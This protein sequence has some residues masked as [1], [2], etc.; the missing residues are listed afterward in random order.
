MVAQPRFEP[1]DLPDSASTRP[2]RWRA[3][4]STLGSL[5]A[6]VLCFAAA[7][8]LGNF[9]TEAI[10]M[11]QFFEAMSLDPLGGHGPHPERFLTPLLAWSIGLTGPRYWAFSQLMLIVFLAL[12]HHLAYVRSRSQP[13]ALVFTLGLSVSGIV[14]TYREMPG[15]SEPTTF[16]LV[17]LCLRFAHRGLLFWLLAG[18]CA[19]N[20]GHS[21]LLWPWLAFERSR[22]ARLGWLDGLLAACALAAYVAARGLL[23]RDSVPGQPEGLG[24]SFY[25]G[26]FGWLRTLEFWTFLVPG[27]VFAFGFLLIVLWWDLCGERGRDASIGALLVGGVIAISLMLATDT[28]RFTA[29]LALPMIAAVHRRLAP[30][31][32][33]FLV[34]VAAV[35]LTVVISRWQHGVLR[36]LMDRIVEF[37]LDGHRNPVLTGL[38]PRYW[39][40]LLAYPVFVALLLPIARWSLPRG[41]TAA[42]RS[43]SRVHS[44]DA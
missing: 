10:E 37:G 25:L 38:L 43:V 42:D 32:R 33:A 34:L 40:I 16:C 24:L 28:F 20:H 22:V 23:I 3:L 41:G 13:W 6:G 9:P 31:R 2:D 5:V 15:Y 14:T 30:D 17:C 8:P 12:V 11:G 36:F 26:T 1:I 19:L 44:L 18:L 27:V 35:G 21:L 4:A 39:P 7:I 29:L